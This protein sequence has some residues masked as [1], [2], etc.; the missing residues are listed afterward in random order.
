VVDSCIVLVSHYVL[1][2][3]GEFQDSLRSGLASHYSALNHR[4][5]VNWICVTASLG[6]LGSAYSR[7]SDLTGILNK[8]TVDIPFH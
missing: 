1:D 4:E 2:S 5:S 3:N 8:R 6:G 7:S